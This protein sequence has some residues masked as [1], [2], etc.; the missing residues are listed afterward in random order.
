[1]PFFPKMACLLRNSKEY[2]PHNYSQIY[3]MKPLTIISVLLLSGLNVFS[4]CPES[5]KQGVHVLKQGE[6]LYR[7]SQQYHVPL[8]DLYAWNN[9]KPNEVIDL[10]REIYI[11]NPTTGEGSRVRGEEGRTK[12]G[13]KTGNKYVKQS[14]G[15]HIVNAG[16][17][18]DG[19]ARLYGY[20]SERFREFNGL[21]VN[22]IIQAGSVLLSSDCNCNGTEAEPAPVS[23]PKDNV[24]SSNTTNSSDAASYMSSDEIDMVAEINLMRS[25]PSGYIPYIEGFIADMKENGEFGT[26]I[27]TAKELIGI[28]KKTKPMG[29]LT[30]LP[31]LYEVAQ[32]HAEDQKPTGDINHQGSDGAWPWDRILKGCTDLV[33]G[34]E[35]IVAG[36]SSVRQSVIILLVDDGIKSRGHRNNLINPDW[37]YVTCYKIG[38]V[39]EMP[40]YWLQLFGN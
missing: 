12:G 5:A 4:Q 19:I 31:C 9:I 3:L 17:T 8:S 1:M 11:T 36:P 10:C 40:N 27:S 30:P 24:S 28:L 20:T 26:A 14:G 35:N 6:N 13:S 34:N 29:K 21:T 32:K 22:Q 39:G 16:E 25:N 37:K 15:K 38:Q 33:D 18:I 23:T 2:L 7:I